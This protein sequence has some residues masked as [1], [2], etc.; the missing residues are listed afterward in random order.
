MSVY[1]YTETGVDNETWDDWVEDIDD[2]KKICLF[3]ST[4]FTDIIDLFEHC[5]KVHSFD[6]IEICQKL[7]LVFYDKIK[8]VNRMR[9]LSIEYKDEIPAE[10]LVINANDAFFDDEVYLKPVLEND[11]IFFE[12]EDLDMPD[13]NSNVISSENESFDLISASKIDEPSDSEKLKFLEKRYKDLE[14]NLVKMTEE[15][16]EYRDFAKKQFLDGIESKPSFMAEDGQANNNHEKKSDYYF[17]S[18]AYNEIH[19]EMIKDSA[20]TDAYRDF[21]Y[22]N[23]SYFKGK[24]VLDV[25]CGTGILSM[26][27]AKAGAAK[28]FAVDNS[29]IIEKA[30]ENVKA[31]DLGNIITLI[32]GKIEDIVLPVEQVDIIISEWMGYFLLFESMLDSVLVARDKFL[33][34]QTGIMGPS[35]ST[36]YLTGVQDDYYINNFVNFWD[37]VYGFN[38]APMKQGL[39]NDAVVTHIPQD[40]QITTQENLLYIDHYNCAAKDL[41]FSSSFCLTVTKDTARLHALAGYFDTYFSIDKT[42]D[43]SSCSDRSLIDEST[44]VLS[45]NINSKSTHWKQTMFLLETPIDVNLGDLLVGV[46]DC[47]KSKTNP[48]ELDVEISYKLL[49]ET[50]QIGLLEIGNTEN[51]D[52]SS[53]KYTKEY[54]SNVVFVKIPPKTQQFSIK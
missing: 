29:N 38:M 28:V 18:Y 50:E 21:I 2:E 39:K 22:K 46:F 20:R 52:M 49:T 44:I 26:F 1:T 5:K 30:K 40:T 33:N 23:K 8:L 7:D 25:G 4:E 45:T 13:D 43:F 54:I 34:K 16:T 11:N 3:C 36:I 24:V 19:M 9:Q 51:A 35:S 32:R 53:K 17:D 42:Q 15:F 31:N 6:F 12:L 37:N 41:D 27:A 47:K 14:S 10:L 48:R